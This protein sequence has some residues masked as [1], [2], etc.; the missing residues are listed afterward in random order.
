M[1]NFMYTMIIGRLFNLLDSHIKLLDKQGR[2]EYQCITC[3]KNLGVQITN[4]RNHVEANH[5]DSGGHSCDFC[6]KI[7]KTTN[8]L[9][10]H[11]SIKHRRS[12]FKC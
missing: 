12:S 3:G 10:S 8:T 6:G 7:Y 1:T 5:I 4:A 2:K 9:K 11:I